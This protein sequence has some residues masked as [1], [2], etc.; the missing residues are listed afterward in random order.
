[1]RA[2][3]RRAWIRLGIGRRGSRLLWFGIVCVIFLALLMASVKFHGLL[4]DMAEAKVKYRTM[5]MVN[6]TVSLAMNRED[7]QFENLI[8]ID[9]DAQGNVQSIHT[10]VTKMNLL[11]STIAEQILAELSEENRI[12]VQVPLSNLFGITLLGGMG[13]SVPVQVIP[14][15]ELQATFQDSFE[16]AGINQTKMQVMMQI[17]V[18]VGVMAPTLQRTVEIDATV[19]VAQAVIVGGVPESYTQ[20]EGTEKNAADIGLE[21]LP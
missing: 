5:Q 17:H 18:S 16:Q 1:M 13:P 12:E 4:L 6:E 20:I 19:P 11:R 3:Q 7:G 9:K 10:D 21:K 2:F 14:L 8:L 15:S